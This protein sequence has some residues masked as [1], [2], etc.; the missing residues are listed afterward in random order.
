MLEL[1][2]RVSRK[3]LVWA[4]AIFLALTALTFVLW[5]VGG[6]HSSGSPVQVQ[7]AQAP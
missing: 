3:L 4:I 1:H 5:S 7:P 2:I 6:G